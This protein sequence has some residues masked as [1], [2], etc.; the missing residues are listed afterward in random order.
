MSPSLRNACKIIIC[1]WLIRKIIQI[2]KWK[3]FHLFIKN[4]IKK[5]KI[6]KGMFVIIAKQNCT[7]C[8]GSL[9]VSR[10]N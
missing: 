2:V 4:K 1:K 5:I 9:N 3:S 7:K 8:R 10:P 6:K